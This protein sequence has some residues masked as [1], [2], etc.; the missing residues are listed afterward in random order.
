MPVLRQS[1]DTKLFEMLENSERKSKRLSVEVKMLRAV[2][3]RRT[4]SM[5]EPEILET[6][7]DPDD[8]EIELKDAAVQ[9]DTLRI[10]SHK[11][12]C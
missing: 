9:V 12:Y 8:D 10:H 3:K 1:D 4:S 7:I 5:K 11:V 6:M 2:L